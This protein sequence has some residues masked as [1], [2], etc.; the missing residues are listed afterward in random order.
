MQSFFFALV[1]I[2]DRRPFPVMTSVQRDWVSG[3]DVDG[4][5]S[6]PS[7]QDWRT[8]DAVL[9]HS[10]PSLPAVSSSDDPSRD[11]PELVDMSVELAVAVFATMI[12]AALFLLAC[13][14]A[15]GRLLA[16]CTRAARGSNLVG[17]STSEMELLRL[18][19]Q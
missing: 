18:P 17:P 10:P 12:S 3:A 5:F 8:D 11:G 9:K 4:D 14:A 15:R 6:F 2:E 13:V 1:I 19:V 16:F 7:G